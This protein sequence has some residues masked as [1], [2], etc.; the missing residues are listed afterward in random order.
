MKLKKNKFII[1]LSTTLLGSVIAAGGEVAHASA[2]PEQTDLTPTNDIV[3]NVVDDY[4]KVVD[5][6]ELEQPPEENT[7]STDTK[8][9]EGYKEESAQASDSS[10]IPQVDATEEN[11][12]STTNETEQTDTAE[13]TDPASEAISEEEALLTESSATTEDPVAVE[14]TEEPSTET[15]AEEEPSPETDENLDIEVEAGSA[16]EDTADTASTEANTVD[17]ASTEKAPASEETTADTTNNEIA[18]ATSTEQKDDA[19]ISADLPQETPAG[20]EPLKEDPQAGDAPLDEDGLPK[21]KEASELPETAEGAQLPVAEEGEEEP[22]I[23]T[24]AAGDAPLTEE[25]AELPLVEEGAEI[26]PGESV[27][28][29][30]HKVEGANAYNLNSQ[31]PDGYKKVNDAIS[32][33]LVKANP[34]YSDPGYFEIAIRV[35][36][37]NRAIDDLYYNDTFNKSYGVLDKSSIKFKSEG[38][39]LA[40]KEDTVN[41]KPEASD[42]VVSPSGRYLLN[43]NY[44]MTPDDLKTIN[45]RKGETIFAISGRYTTP[46]GEDDSQ[47]GTSHSVKGHLIPYPNEN[48]DG[49]IISVNKSSVNGNDKLNDIPVTEDSPNRGIENGV[50]DTGI[51][52]DNLYA[53][54][55]DGNLLED[56]SNR[57]TGRVYT[58]SG[59]ELDDV[60]VFFDGNSVKLKLP[61]GAIKDENSVFNGDLKD[62]KDLEVELFIRPRTDDEISNL[63]KDYGGIED[64]APDVK[65]GSK[66]INN[67]IANGTGTD[68]KED[69]VTVN[70][71]DRVRYDNFNTLGRFEISLDDHSNYDVTYWKDGKDNTDKVNRL[72]AGKTSTIEERYNA[73]NSVLKSDL[74]AAL[75][76]KIAERKLDTNNLTEVGPNSYENEDGWK[77]DID[78]EAKTFNVTPPLNAK[79]GDDISLSVEFKFTNGSTKDFPLIFRVNKEAIETPKYEIKEDEP[80]TNINSTPSYDEDPDT[81]QPDRIELA[82]KYNEDDHGNLWTVTIDEK[83]GNITATTPNEVIGEYTLRVPV[84]AYYKDPVKVDENG[85]PIE[86]IRRTYAEF[87]TQATKPYERTYTETEPL[88]Y[89]VKVIKD[90]ELEAG[91][92]ELVQQG[93]NGAKE[94]TYNQKYNNDG[95]KDGAPTVVDEKVLTEA[96]THIIKVGTKT[97]NTKTITETIPFDYKVEYDENLEA[98][99]YE[100]DPGKDGSKTT[101]WNIVNSEIVGEPTVEKTD[102]VQGVIRVG[103]KDFTGDVTYKDKEEIP[104]KVITKENPDLAVGTTRVTTPGEVGTREVTYTVPVRNGALDS[105]DGK[106]ITSTENITKKPVDEVVEI[107]TKP[108]EERVEIPFNT[109]YKYDDTL[110]AGEIVEE[111]AGQNG[112]NKVVTSYDPA[113]KSA[114]MTEEVVKAPTNR[115]VRVGGKTNG[116]QTVTEKVPFEVEVKENPALKKG[117]YKVIQEGVVGEKEKILTIENSKV[118]DTAE[119]RT[120]TE[121]KNQIIEVGSADF[122]GEVTHEVTEEVPFTVKIVEDPTMAPGTHK[123]VTEG[124]A[125]SKT[126]RY[127]QNIKNGAADGDLKSEEIVTDTTKAPVEEVIHVGTAPVN[128]VDTATSG[129]IPVDIT[130]TYDPTKDRGTAEKGTFTPGKVETKIV[131]QYNPETGKIETTT[132]ETVTNATQEIIVGTKDYTGTFTHEERRVTPFETQIVHDPNLKAGETVTDQ[133]GVNGV[134]THTITQKFTNGDIA[135]KSYSDWTTVSEV[136]NEIIRVGSLTEGTQKHE[137]AIP[138]DY[139]VEYDPTIPAGE[140][141]IAQEG[142]DGKRTT[143]W[144]IKNSQVVGEPTV[145]EEAPVN[146]IIKVGNKDFTGIATHTEDFTI[147]YKVVIR[148]NPELPV[149][150]RKTVQEGTDGSYKITY[151]QNI[152]N[153]DTVGE[154]TRTESDRVEAQNQIIEIGTKAVDPKVDNYSYE[155]QPEIDYVYVDTLPKGTV[156]KGKTTPGEVKT[157]ITTTRDPQTGQLVTKEEKIVSPARQE[158]RVGTKDYT[159][160]VKYTERVYEDY[161]TTIIQ[162]PNLAADEQVVE[163]SG[164]V[165]IKEREVTRTITNGTAS[166]P[167]FGD[168]TTIA[169]KQDQVIRVGTK[170][171]GTHTVTEEL[172]FTYTINEVDTLKKGEYEVVTAGKNGS[173]TTE[174][175]IENS[176]VVEGSAT[177]TAETPATNAVINVGKGTLN[178]THT[179][180]ETEVVPY[181]TEIV[182]DDTLKAGQQDVVN[183]GS[184]GSKS[185]KV[186]LTIEDGKVVATNEGAYTEDSAPVNRKVR[187]GTLTEGTITHEEKIPF[188]Y[189]ITYDP[190]VAAGTYVTD[191]EG[192]EGTRTTTWTITNSTPLKTGEV[193]EGPTNAKIRV[194]SKDFTG[195][196]TNA[197]TEPI[198]YKVIVRENPDMLLGTSKTV[199][200]GK[201]GTKEVTYNIPVIN[202]EQDTTKEVTSSE[203]VT[204]EAVDQV[205]EVGTKPVEAVEKDVSAEVGVEVEIVNDP[206]LDLGKTRTGELVPGKVENTV[207]TVYNPATGKME[208]REDKVVTPAKQIIYVGT[209]EL[210]GTQEFVVTQPVPFETEYIEDPNLEAGK[211]EVEQQGQNG[212]KTVTYKA[213]AKN[214]QVTSHKATEEITKDPVKQIIR[215][216]T[217]SEET[218]T[219]VLVE[220]IP[221]EIE[222]EYTDELEA[223]K[224]EVKQEGEL[225]EKTTTTTTTTI[226]GEESVDKKE[227]TTKEPVKRIVRVGTKIDRQTTDVI[228]TERTII[229]YKT[230]VIYD[231]NLKAGEKVVDKQGVNGE[232]K[233]TVTVPVVDGVAGNPVVETEDTVQAQDEIIRVGTRDDSTTTVI[234]TTTTTESIPFE[235]EYIEDD[236]LAL[237]ET[238]VKTAGEFGSKTVTT[239]TT[240]INGKANVSTSEDVTKE[241]VNQVVR[242]GTKVPK[243]D[244][245][246]VTETRDI[247]V[248]YSTIIQYN[249][250]MDVGSSF[251]AQEGE[252]GTT[253]ITTTVEVVDGVAGKP[254]ITTTTKDPKTR[255]VQIGSKPVTETVT[256]VVEFET[257]VIFDDTLPIGEERV[258]E[259][260]L[261]EDTTTITYEL[262]NGQVTAST[263]TKRTK[264][265]KKQIIRVGTKA[266]ELA[267]Q[268][269]EDTR[270]IEIPYTTRII[271]D[272]TLEA[273][274]ERVEET[275]EKGKRVITYKVEVRDGIATNAKIVDETTTDPKERVIRVGTRRTDTITTVV[276]TVKPFETKIVYDPEMPKGTSEVTQEGKNGI[277]R[278]TIVSTRINGVDQEN[279]V[280]TISETDAIDQIITVGTKCDDQVATIDT[281]V[282]KVT[283]YEVEIVYDDTL[284]KGEEV[285]LREGQ[286]GIVK[287]THTVTVTNGVAGESRVTKTENVQDKINKIIRV[288]TKVNPVVSNNNTIKET[289]IEVI[290]F[291]TKFIYTDELAAGET[292]VLVEGKNGKRI[293]K[294][295]ETDTNGSVDKDRSEVIENPVTQIIRVGIN[296]ASQATKTTFTKTENIPYEYQI[297]ND[298]NMEAGTYEVVQEGRVGEKS[299]TYTLVDSVIQDDKTVET[300]IRDPQDLIIRIGTKKTT[301]T[302]NSVKPSK[303]AEPTVT[304][305][306]SEIPYNTIFIYDDS[307]EAGKK[308]VTSPGQ[309]GEKIVTITS[310]LVNGEIV[311]ETSEVILKEARTEYVRVG[312][313]AP[314]YDNQDEL[315]RETRVLVPFE[316]EIIY[317]EN[318]PLGET[319]VVSEGRDGIQVITITTRYE[320]GKA[321]ETTT[322]GYVLREAINRVV[323]VG[324]KS[325]NDSPVIDENTGIID[326]PT[327]TDDND[328][329]IVIP[330]GTIDDNDHVVVIP[331]TEDTTEDTTDDSIENESS[332]TDDERDANTDI[333]ESDETERTDI[334]REAGRNDAEKEL[335]SDYFRNDNQVSIPR[336]A[337][338][339]ASREDS[340]SD[341]PKTGIAGT[342]ATLTALGISL[343]GLGFSKKK[344]EDDEE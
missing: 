319:V 156:E 93:K 11:E 268:D 234:N 334:S 160:E 181:E 13:N 175:R 310:K 133:V 179:I 284:A 42:L 164:V 204:T 110:K 184:N 95:T 270:T 185:R 27:K 229:P 19:N 253:T 219:K 239:S 186:T 146:A 165:G 220:S 260:E 92:E 16:L 328:H 122:T 126:T 305:I 41:F 285:V 91:K 174:Y 79:K 317:D 144:T 304:K 226:N 169:E 210:V 49:D 338:K 259:G 281:E 188:T 206:E 1:G 263:K 109:E 187:V 324:T 241:P 36:T 199:T 325:N 97:E 256:S 251:V 340:K 57:I 14:E 48:N 213:E 143:E 32:Y 337:T 82:S 15:T 167:S 58:K 10:E 258:E 25:G 60:R 246:T 7:D 129:D 98:E 222:Y 286:N 71:Y 47:F 35:D 218:D 77:V 240:L 235:T 248:P 233:I 59:K 151:K 123:V 315:T 278:E 271:Y 115:V 40:G 306:R 159:G 238:V 307:I 29:S 320:N 180:T 45:D 162:D 20:D 153:G 132:E 300:T 119:G 295:T 194:G 21:T 31:A 227:E 3:E 90:P 224:I 275:G 158:I 163:T 152:K 138:F 131:N 149:G 63:Y 94:I 66:S 89:D 171:D 154:L 289:E 118:T 298:P 245:Q 264:E 157:V 327:N 244:N 86:Y 344:K 223:G 125:G 231:P 221:F 203:K 85:E 8:E 104:Y 161:K 62:Y 172:P 136:K 107:G 155:V 250:K 54:D 51:T 292:E 294:Y 190:T 9:T 117:E 247:E 83:T 150:T 99:K 102:P 257:E 279:P 12:A 198:P 176:K 269:I 209:K 137:E 170:T 297:I 242:V 114:K 134:E 299:I 28:D 225:G 168:Y 287:E 335:G 276:E 69:P 113:T 130:Y 101:T 74:D 323:R 135:E 23:Q 228:G 212:Q 43:L 214:G 277:K 272:D 96:T 200:D 217:R 6:T 265:P 283:P 76:D 177:V 106:A 44:T 68:T 18:D 232:R 182:F 255:I 139:K 243:L 216:G 192:K 84:T 237:G 252:N 17:E 128:S 318:L 121:A 81:V 211:T 105:K 70:T 261:G 290:P 100:I 254:V 342:G 78:E 173:R 331:E 147:P 291:E 108:I 282:E 189:E 326:I 322:D 193:T 52:I 191:V 116:S 145:T 215:V 178:G 288:G 72:T 183:E 127:T 308:V 4:T 313:K 103:S 87:K 55:S 34:T 202:G 24:L 46:P 120:I 61:E 330:E 140:Y 312:T 207:T 124:Q 316:T 195:T 148:E 166:D 75:S 236:T 332:Q 311:T 230:T 141:K 88:V 65:S 5:D 26:A 333:E 39:K 329:S 111:T 197:T 73:Y 280:V 112:T 262:V 37:T 293:Y 67:E 80:N 296:K 321:I 201:A 336:S 343:A 196:V 274:T 302:D 22:K 64:D 301:S 205:I 2:L 33:R 38:D 267:D 142:K 208:T 249:D 314:K 339:A 341:N 266:A 303:P 53:Y 309:K 273:G 56:N 30:E 50:Y